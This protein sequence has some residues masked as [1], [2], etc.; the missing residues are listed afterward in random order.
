MTV[1]STALAAPPAHAEAVTQLDRVTPVAV[2]EGRAAWSTHDA[3]TGRYSLTTR[4]DGVTSTVPVA[5]RPVPF[6][7]DLGP[8]SN[9]AVTATY[10]RCRVYAPP[11]E[12]AQGCDIYLYDFSRGR[13]TRVV[14]ASAAHANESWPS[15]WRTHLAFAREYDNKPRLGYL[16]TRSIASGRPSTRMPGGSRS[17]CEHCNPTPP[18]RAAQL[19][20]YGSRLGFTWTYLDNGEGFDSEIRLDTIGD[21]HERVAH[22]NGGGLTQVHLGWPAFESGKLYWSISCYGDEA[23]CPGRYG[24]RRLRYS[25]GAVQRADGPRDPLG[26]D[27]DGGQTYLLTDAQIGSDCRGDPAMPGGTCTL[28]SSSPT[29]G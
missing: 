13:E 24:L 6:D 12:R 29:F 23:G 4:V 21:G 8:R 27:R 25:T 11:A 18:S 7:V 16:Y 3:A 26:H 2:Y 22:Q 5:S 1:V 19:D 28:T 15:L 20:L 9:G 14:N 17:R 10:S